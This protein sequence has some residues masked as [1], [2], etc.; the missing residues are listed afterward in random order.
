LIEHRVNGYLA[1][2][3]EVDELARGLGLILADGEEN[4]ALRTRAVSKVQREFKQEDVCRRYLA[5]YEEIASG[6]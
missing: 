2:P 4:G 1:K 5:L 3:F 6:A